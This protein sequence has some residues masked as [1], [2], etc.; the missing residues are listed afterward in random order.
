MPTEHDDDDHDATTTMA[1]TTTS[2]DVGS[3]ATATT[4]TIPSDHP[5]RPVNEKPSE[6]TDELMG[7]TL[8]ADPVSSATATDTAAA[9]ATGTAGSKSDHFL[10]SFFP[11][12]GV[13]KRTQIWIYG[14]VTII[15][16]FC[17]GLGAYFY[18]ARRKRLRTNAREHYEFEVLN[19]AEDREAMLGGADGARGKRRAGELYDAFAG[20]SDEE[21]FSGDEKDYRDEEE[22]DDEEARDGRVDAEDSPE[23]GRP[24][25]SR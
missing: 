23:R 2:I 5:D 13:S 7:P 18:L 22:D 12:F 20:E 11:T 19:D 21:I 17:A 9:S 10:P 4:T 24:T 3:S 8:T 1:A 6:T 15:V 25:S 14:A 16:L